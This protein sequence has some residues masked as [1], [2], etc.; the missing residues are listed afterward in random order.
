MSAKPTGFDV[1]TGLSKQLSASVY[2]RAR[3]IGSCGVYKRW[4][5]A[6]A[7]IRVEGELRY[8]ED[9]A[10]HVGQGE[11][12]LSILIGEDNHIGHFAGQHMHMLLRIPMPG[13]QQH[14]QPGPDLPDRFAV[15]RNI[16]ILY[17]L[18]YC[19]H[20]ELKVRKLKVRK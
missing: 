19:S 17:T 20:G 2:Q 3:H 1:Y 11:I 4:A 12:E 15:Y 8:K 13:S 6:F 18:D 9:R 14:K 10:A 7:G 5:P 16:R